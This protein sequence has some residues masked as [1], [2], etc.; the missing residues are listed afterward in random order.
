LTFSTTSFLLRFDPFQSTQYVGQL[1]LTTERLILRGWRESDREPFARISADPEVR[2]HFVRR[3]TQ[4]ES[5][6]FA[7][8]IGR[9]FD[10]HGYGPWA[11][12][13][14]G[15]APFI[16]FVGLSVPSFEAPFM[17]AVEI[18]W[19]LN[20]PFWGK[21]YAT[22]A[23]RAAIDDGFGRL[24]LREIVSFTSPDNTRSIAVMER[25]GMTHDPTDDFDHPNVP[26]GHRL[27]RHV[28]YRIAPGR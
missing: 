23:A 11:L 6:G 17:P 7:D 24:G 3:M 18:G 10:E 19:R 1:R 13:I 22:E 12:E 4:E 2:R 5:D 21:G 9:Q 26:E 28:L 15:E 20:K 14:P 25:V 16:G 8:R 27:R